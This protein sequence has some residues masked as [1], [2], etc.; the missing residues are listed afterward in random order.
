MWLKDR[1]VAAASLC[2]N[3]AITMGR[4]NAVVTSEKGHF[5]TILLH[6]TVAKLRKN[7]HAHHIFCQKTSFLS[8]NPMIHRRKIDFLW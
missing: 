6:L 1:A 2:V 4:K 7:Y 5:R 8:L 3:A